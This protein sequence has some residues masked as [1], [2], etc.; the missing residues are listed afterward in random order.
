MNITEKIEKYLSE[1]TKELK[2]KNCNNTFVGV[3]GKNI[4]GSRCPKCGSS[5]VCKQSK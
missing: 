3:R 5:E 4:V 1:A 2:C